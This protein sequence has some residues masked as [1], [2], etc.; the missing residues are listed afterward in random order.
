MAALVRSKVYPTLIQGVSQQAKQQRRDSQCEE[1]VNCVN[2]IVSGVEARNGGKILHHAFGLDAKDAFF[3]RIRR[4]KD[5][6]YIV[7]IKPNNLMVYNLL[8]GQPCTVTFPDGY[9]YLNLVRYPAPF[10][11]QEPDPTARAKDSFTAVSLQD[12]T[13]IAN[14]TWLPNADGTPSTFAPTRPPEA[15]FYFRAGAY[16][17]KYSIAVRFNNTTY[18]WSYETPDNS[19]S[20]NAEY[21]TTTQLAATF[22]RAMGGVGVGFNASGEGLIAAEHPGHTSGVSAPSQTLTSLGF[23]IVID[24]NV[25]RIWRNDNQSF[26]LSVTD[27]QGGRQLI[28]FQQSIENFSDLPKSCFEGYIVRVTGSDRTRDDD[29]FVRFA[30]KTGSDGLW[31]ECPAPGVGTALASHTMPHILQNEAPNVFSFKRI[32][33]GRRVAGD[34]VTTALDPSFLG[35]NIKELFYDRGRLGILTEGSLVWSRNKQPFVFFPDTVQTTLA[36]DPVDL[37]VSYKE[38]VLLQRFVAASG[39][40]MVWADGIQFSLTT[41]EQ[42]FKQETAEA[43]PMAEFEFSNAAPPLSV[44]QLLFFGVD[45][46]DFTSI[47]DVVVDRGRLLNDNTT[48]A[49]VPRYLPGGFRFMAASASLSMLI[50]H[51]SA[52]PNVVW[53]YQWLFTDEGRVQAAWSKWDFPPTSEILW[54][55]FTSSTLH[56]LVQRPTGLLIEEHDLSYLGRDSNRPLRFRLDH[57]FDSTQV[58]NMTYTEPLPGFAGTADPELGRTSF[59]AP[60]FMNFNGVPPDDMVCV[61]EADFEED[62]RGK[63][64]RVVASPSGAPLGTVTVEGDLRGRSFRCGFKI[65]SRRKFS[66]FFEKQPSGESI[67]AESVILDR[68]TIFHGV[69]G[70]Y[71]VQVVTAGAPYNYEYEG[72]RLGEPSMTQPGLAAFEGSF[73]VPLSADSKEAEITLIN[74]SPYPSAWSAAEWFYQVQRSK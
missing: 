53:V 36:T 4:G 5:E 24:G 29:Y 10:F 56:V 26:R 27:G 32:T 7:I 6:Q 38:I 66:E 52:A 15:C 49:H 62:Y 9:G 34:G 50:A 25:V 21:I 41:N 13:I 35:Q 18:K 57:S 40:R 60:S 3:Y 28:G 73:T 72:R 14:K 30:G 46:G 33:W 51:C 8:T 67:T 48:T 74:D 55:G 65:N 58:T 11:T 43:V 16:S 22:F 19:T 17:T 71:R 37:E 54:Y 2:S 42:T 59:M 45:H 61:L 44:G 1:Q 70:Y 12:A 64:Y 20:G 69:T 68:L 39:S 63:L 31:L 47:M 23:N